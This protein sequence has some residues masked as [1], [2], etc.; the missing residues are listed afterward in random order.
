[1]QAMNP[2][3]PEEEIIIAEAFL[4]AN[5]ASSLLRWLER[6]DAVKRIANNF[7]E[8]DLIDFIQQQVRKTPR[9]E[10]GLGK[11]YAFLVALILKR[12]QQGLLGLP[13]ISPQILRWFNHFWD[14][15]IFRQISTNQSTI[16]SEL[17]PPLLTTQEDNGATPEL[18]LDHRGHPIIRIRR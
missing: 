16:S 9:T 11:A 14:N 4:V 18:L 12:R 15:A 2:F 8:D 3:S 5:T 7:L 10:V 13:P 1:M 17:P 6:N